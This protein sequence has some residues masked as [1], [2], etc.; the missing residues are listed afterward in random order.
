[1]T[2]PCRTVRVEIA[3]ATLA[4]QLADGQLCAGELRC[5]DGESKQGLLRLCLKR[6]RHRPLLTPAIPGTCRERAGMQPLTK[7]SNGRQGSCLTHGNDG[8]RGKGPTGL[9]CPLR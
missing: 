9:S 5:L 3:E 8:C 6:C 4:R 2:T 1:M 7:I